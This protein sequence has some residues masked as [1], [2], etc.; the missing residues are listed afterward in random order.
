MTS[1]QWV[2]IALSV[3]VAG[4]SLFTLVVFVE[5]YIVQRKARKD[6]A[7][8]RLPK[9]RVERILTA[10]QLAMEGKSDGRSMD[11]PP[12][13]EALRDKCE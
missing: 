2:A 11:T 9:H 4:W 3:F 5:A 12:G 1:F 7:K 10:E 13:R 8:W 6:Y